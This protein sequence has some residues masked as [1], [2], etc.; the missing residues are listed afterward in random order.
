MNT[1]MAPA[2]LAMSG[3]NSSKVNSAGNLIQPGN[4]IQ[5]EGRIPSQESH[6]GLR[7]RCGYTC[8]RVCGLC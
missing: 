5:E 6:A 1:S 8:V 4:P 3:K 2:M 7:C